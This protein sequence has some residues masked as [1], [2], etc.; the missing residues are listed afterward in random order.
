MN[1]EVKFRLED[2]NINY[3]PIVNNDYIDTDTL[4]NCDYPMLCKNSSDFQFKN[5]L[6]MVE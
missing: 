1:N 3:D 6:Q 5:V 2:L 4:S